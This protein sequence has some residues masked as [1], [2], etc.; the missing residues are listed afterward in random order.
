MKKIMILAISAILAANVSAQE[1]KAHKGECKKEKK[2]CRF[3]PEQR[4]EMDI[5]YL[6]EELYLDSVQALK[7]A[8][9]YREYAAEKSK[10]NEKYKALFSQSLNDRQVKAVL[11][12][13]GPRPKA[14]FNPGEMPDKQKGEF[15]QPDGMRADKKLKKA[16][17]AEKDD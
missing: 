9:T 11:R 2:E 10:L 4:V 5:K 7:F 8:D 6:S 16:K 13:H 15:R 1:V 12:Y 14:V 3:T 17:K